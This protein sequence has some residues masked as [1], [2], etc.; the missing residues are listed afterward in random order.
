MI[1]I[2]RGSER[3][4]QGSLANQGEVMKLGET[5]Q[6]ILIFHSTFSNLAT[7]EIP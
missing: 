3:I 6:A 7:V 2:H 5:P 1:A 4:P